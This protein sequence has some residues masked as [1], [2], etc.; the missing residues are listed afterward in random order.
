MNKTPQRFIRLPE[1]RRLTGMSRTSIY[2]AIADGR[3]PR[4]LKAGPKTSV[5]QESDIAKWQDGIV[6]ASQ[7][8]AA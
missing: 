5:W 1:V 6:A 8:R 4:P 2:A 3:F 7:S